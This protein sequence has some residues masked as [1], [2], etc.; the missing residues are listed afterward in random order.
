M[1]EGDAD[2]IQILAGEFSHAGVYC[3][4]LAQMLAGQGAVHDGDSAP[5]SGGTG[6][7]RLERR[8]RGRPIR[9][10]RGNCL[11]RKFPG[12]FVVVGQEGRGECEDALEFEASQVLDR[13]Q[14]VVE[15]RLCKTQERNL[16]EPAAQERHFVEKPRAGERDIRHYADTMRR[17]TQFV[18]YGFAPIGSR[19]R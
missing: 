15:S 7:P 10:F 19:R 18:V 12:H 4:T 5:E 3:Q 2:I 8:H 14:G 6:V 9:G 16:A 17:I 13:A 1:I 11:N